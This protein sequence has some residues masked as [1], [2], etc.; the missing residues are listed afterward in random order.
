ME[1]LPFEM[2]EQETSGSS[3]AHAGD[4]GLWGRGMLGWVTEAPRRQKASFGRRDPSN[5][6]PKPSAQ[7]IFQGLKAWALEVF[8]SSNV[9]GGN[10]CHVDR[11]PFY[12]V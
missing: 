8:W 11:E 2:P 6:L 1:A 3:S 5:M 4:R 9:W 12:A 7:G 10:L